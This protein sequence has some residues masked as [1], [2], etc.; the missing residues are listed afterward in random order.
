MIRGTKARI[1]TRTILQTILYQPEKSHHV[2]AQKS[3]GIY[4]AIIMHKYTPE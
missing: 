2:S 3:H 1:E 4:S